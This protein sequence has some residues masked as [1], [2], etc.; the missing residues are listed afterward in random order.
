MACSS[1]A[2]IMESAGWMLRPEIFLLFLL[3]LIKGRRTRA[4]PLLVPDEL[5]NLVRSIAQQD[6]GELE[7]ECK[8]RGATGIHTSL[9]VKDLDKASEKIKEV[10]A[11]SFVILSIAVLHDDFGF[12]EK[13]CQRFRNGL[14]RAA[15]Y[16]NDGLAEWIDYVDAIKEE[17]G[18]VL[19]NP[20][21]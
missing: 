4:V 13:R 18:I 11:D 15:D 6:A 3:F 21:E 14:D 9:A 1:W 16:I 10:I 12:G 2:R 17:L 20:A 8:F 7:Q 5:A 19:K